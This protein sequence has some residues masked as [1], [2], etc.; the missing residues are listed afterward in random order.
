MTK[1]CLGTKLWCIYCSKVKCLG[2]IIM[3]PFVHV[4]QCTL[5]HGVATFSWWIVTCLGA[6]RARSLCPVLSGC[7]GYKVEGRSWTDEWLLLT[8]LYNFL[9]F[10]HRSQFGCNLLKG[11]VE[12]HRAAN[13][14]S[15][16][17][18]RQLSIWLGSS[19]FY[20]TLASGILITLY[21]TGAGPFAKEA[22]C[23]LYGSSSPSTWA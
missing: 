21:S 4:V 9:L 2:H 20:H 22:V 18:C 12:C 5:W 16:A 6:L 23:E 15:R 1:T 8:P 19:D 13:Q 17:V 11:K 14:Q 3:P 7:W 10:L